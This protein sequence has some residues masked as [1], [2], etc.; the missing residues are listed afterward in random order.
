M[1]YLEWVQKETLRMFPPLTGIFG[2]EAV[3]DHYIGNI[4]IKKDMIVIGEI[5]ANHWSKEG[6]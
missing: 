5:I 1:T 3:K 2:R 6:F 4:P